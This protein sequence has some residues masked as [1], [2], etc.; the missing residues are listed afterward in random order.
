MMTVLAIILQMRLVRGEIRGRR[1]RVNDQIVHATP[2][3]ALCALP[4][5]RFVSQ[6]F[7]DDLGLRQVTSPGGARNFQKALIGDCNGES[8]HLGKTYYPSDKTTTPM[9]LRQPT[10][11][12]VIVDCGKI[13]T[14]TDRRYK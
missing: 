7:T 5:C 1:I 10:P 6:P 9:P 4:H 3:R 2:E 14:V 13:A 8:F 11:P 12:N